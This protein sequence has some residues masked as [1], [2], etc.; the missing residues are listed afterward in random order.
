ML[1]LPLDQL[2]LVVAQAALLVALLA[3]LWSAGLHR[4]YP[5]FFGYLLVELV[6]TLVGSFIPFQGRAYRHFWVASEGIVAC[7]YALIV[8]ELYRV[9]LRDL[10]GIASISR[11]YI[12]ATVAVATAGS[13]LLLRL[14]ETPENYVSKFLVIERAIVFSL[15]L[16]ILLVS[17]FLAYYPIPLNRNVVIYSI[18]YAV[19]FLTKAT[20]LFIRTLGHYVSRQTSTLMLLVSSAC[21]LFWVITL[22]RQGELR[23]VVIGHK[24]KREDETQLLSKLKAIN[25]TL[26]SAG[27]K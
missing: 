22:N 19:Y 13:L 20:A 23:T 17:V 8:V 10:P 15:V 11:R 1:Q 2:V 27:K 9:V 24:W 16:F 3:R 5:Y 14:E 7:C 21:L 18:G 26:V 25:A 6:R 12:T 4:V